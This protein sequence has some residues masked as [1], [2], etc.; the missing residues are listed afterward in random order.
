MEVSPDGATMLKGYLHR[1]PRIGSF[2]HEAAVALLG[3]Q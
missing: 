2:E 1:F 3:T